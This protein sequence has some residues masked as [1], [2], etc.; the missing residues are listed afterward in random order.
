MASPHENYPSFGDSSCLP[1]ASGWN[2][3]L[4]EAR[5]SSS[6][7][8]H[9]GNN[10]SNAKQ[11]EDIL[12]SELSKLSV[13]ER[14]EAYDDVHCV[15]D[16]LQ[17]TPEMV[18]RSLLEFEQAIPRYR[19]TAYELACKQNKAYIEDPSFRLRFLRAQMHNVDKAVAQMMKFL[20]YKGEFFGEDKIASEITLDDLDEEDMEL[21]L[22]GLFHIQAER[23]RMGRIIMY[24]LS[25]MWGRFKPESTVSCNGVL[26]YNFGIL[27]Y[28]P[29]VFSIE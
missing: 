26:R 12:S 5:T 20:K 28:S 17:E 29:A 3:N 19:N 24:L 23:D 27:E 10:S 7:P 15:G 16:E 8:S 22:S 2:N 21:M 9:D 18:Q 13:K 11:I 6:Q 1:C 25:K 14:S 4:W